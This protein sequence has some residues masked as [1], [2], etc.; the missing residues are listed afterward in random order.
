MAPPHFPLAAPLLLSTRAEPNANGSGGALT[1]SAHSRESATLESNIVEAWSQGF[2][3][4]AIIILMFVTIA[5]M[6]RGVW[7]HKLILLEVSATLPRSY[8][9]AKQARLLEA[10]IR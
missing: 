8:G 1:G 4:G 3:F 7:L 9:K 6:R 2:M 10:L 5:N